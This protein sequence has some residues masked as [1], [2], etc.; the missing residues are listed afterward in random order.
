MSGEDGRVLAGA[1]VLLLEDDAL[2]NLNST[3]MIEQMGC[4]VRSYMSVE[5]GFAAAQ[6]QLPHVAVLDI[7]IRGR[8]SYDLA[9]WLRERDVP[10]VFVTGYDSPAIDGHWREVPVCRKPCAPS[11][12]RELLEAALIRRGSR[13]PS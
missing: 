10:I 8:L 13:G 4:R 1:E 3:D 12:L 6:E 9:D 5:D 7:N 2:I 11:S